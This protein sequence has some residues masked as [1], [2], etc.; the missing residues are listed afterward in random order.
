MTIPIFQ[1]DAFA[2]RQFAGNPA[3]V[4]PL[5]HWLDDRILQGIS[6]ENNLSETAFFVRTGDSFQLRWFTPRVEVNLCGHATLAS[7][8]ILFEKLDW[9]QEQILFDTKSGRLT[10]RKFKDGSLT[11]DFPSDMPK[12]VAA[13]PAGLKE[14][15]GVSP[16]E[17]L[18]AKTDYLV[19]LDSEEEVMKLDPDFGKLS[20]LKMRGLIVSAPGKDADFVSR[21]FAPGVG[22]NEDPVTGSAHTILAP[23]WAKRLN[24]H[25]LSALQ[26]SRRGGVLTCEIKQDRVLISGRC[27]LYLEGKIYVEVQDFLEKSAGGPPAMRSNSR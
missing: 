9:Q 4:C 1:A 3:A 19:I 6:E 21:F 22:I 17:L 20:Q 12:P 8:Y 26:L 13:A 15:L 25:M 7:A 18:Q 14:G 10:V 2:E 5:E 24:K 23:Y 16:M 11:L 27:R